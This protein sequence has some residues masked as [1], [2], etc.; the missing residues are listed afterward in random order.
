MKKII[1]IVLL[2]LAAW[3]CQPAK[4]KTTE[5]A[6]DSTFVKER[7]AFMSNMKSAQ[8][9]AAQ[10]QATGADFNPALM[11]IP[12]NYA[13]LGADTLKRAANLGVYLADLNYSVAYK[14]SENTKEIFQS[15]YN[16]SK[17]L[18]IDE[19]MLSFIS[20]RYE[21]NIGQNDSV[22]SAINELFKHATESIQGTQKE[23][24]LGVVMSGYTMENLHL[25]L[26]AIET[27]PK[28]ILPEDS[29]IQILVPLFKM[30]LLQEPQVESVYAFLR[31]L[32]DPSDPERTPNFA[33]FDQSFS[34][35]LEVYQRLNV[36]EAISNNQ[37]SALMNDAVV[38]ELS[39]KVNAIRN[40]IVTP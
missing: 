19:A 20:Q 8:E 17:S 35:L 12:I 33:F 2:A 37:G 10:I 1:P 23:R 6:L 34:E 24:V 28:D 5:T 3:S 31:T 29:R 9:S 21:T 27:Y 14:Q 30:V 40:K 25:A 36:D 18:G 13:E 4:E 7:T 39:S 32:G 11:N 38:A 16:L 15:A 22:K 26:G